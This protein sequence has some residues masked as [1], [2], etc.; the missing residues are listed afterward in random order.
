MTTKRPRE[1]PFF[2]RYSCCGSIELTAPGMSLV[3]LLFLAVA[4]VLAACGD[5]PE[6]EAPPAIPL[7]TLPGVYAGTFPCDGCPGIGTTLWLQSDG[8]FF[9][10]QSYPENNERDAFNAFNLGLWRW[11]NDKQYLVLTGAGPVRT[12]TRPEADSLLMQVGSEAEHRLRRDPAAP[13]FVSRAPLA[14]TMRVQ[15]KSAS[16]TECL[17]G[18]SVPVDRGGDY[19]RFILQYRSK[20]QRGV[21]AYVELEGRFSWTA[22]GEPKSLIID[23]FVSIKPDGGC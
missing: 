4:A 15:D 7:A 8:R 12:F 3:R 16:F 1:G 18:I 13:N 19:R 23:R 11:D 5:K 22:E 2:L 17:T 6:E 20:A 10:R 14:G 21:P 9:L